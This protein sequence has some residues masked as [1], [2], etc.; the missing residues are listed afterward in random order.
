MRVGALNYL[1]D[2]MCITLLALCLLS[3]LD[4]MNQFLFSVLNVGQRY[5]TCV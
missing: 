5:V 2:Y 4:V 1:H 3:T